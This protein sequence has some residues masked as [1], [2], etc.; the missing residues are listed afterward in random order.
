MRAIFPTLLGGVL[1]LC[2]G[3]RDDRNMLDPVT[4]QAAEVT[5][6][7]WIF[8]GTTAVVYVVVM[9][10]VLAAIVRARSR[11]VEAPDRTRD[12]TSGLYVKGAVTATVLV[13][14]ALLMADLF[15]VRG[16]AVPSDPNTVNIKITGHQWWW[17]AEYQDPDASKVVTTANEIHLPLGKPVRFLLQSADVIH[18]FWLPNLQGKKDAIPGHPGSFWVRP[19]RTGTYRGQCAEFCGNQHAHM[20]LVAMVESPADFAKWRDAQLQE[21]RE[22]STELERRGREIFLTRTCVMCHTIAGTTAASH[23]GPPLTHF[24]SRQTFAAGSFPLTAENLAAW[25]RD[26]QAMKPGVRMPATP[27]TGD[28]IS[29]LVAYLGSLK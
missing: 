8:A 13:L 23:V 18:S 22:P 29:C 16:L 10:V 12:V 3:C 17:Q 4:P 7:W 15:V 2:A 9:G 6:L 26:P 20:G 1:L 24:A 19:E 28:E 21:A 5:R 27:L 11:L 25:I 14:V